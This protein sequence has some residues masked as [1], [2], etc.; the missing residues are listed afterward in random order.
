[1]SGPHRTRAPNLSA[2]AVK[3]SQIGHSGRVFVDETLERVAALL[4]LGKQPSEDLP[5]VATDALVRGL[6]SPSLRVLA[7]TRPGDVREKRD[8]FWLALSELAIPQPSEIEARWSLVTD[9]ARDIIDDR[10]TPLSG[11]RRI[12]WEGWEELGRPDELTVF[13]GLASKWE[14]DE[15]HRAEYEQDI[16]DAAAALLA[17]RS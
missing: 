2:E 3:P 17:R 14:D 11:A 16:R 8:L 13:V 7:G 15:A 9:W 6:D 10:L 1:M 12:W 5:G 4:A